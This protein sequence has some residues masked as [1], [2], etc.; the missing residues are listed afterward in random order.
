MA[1]E[2]TEVDPIAA[3]A[4]LA[5]NETAV[6]TPRF[7]ER[8]GDAERRA[9]ARATA[10]LVLGR[11]CTEV[12]KMEQV[13]TKAGK[14]L[15]VCQSVSDEMRQFEMDCA[16]AKE[17]FEARHATSK[18]VDAIRREFNSSVDADHEIKNTANWHVFKRTCNTLFCKVSKH[19]RINTGKKDAGKAP[20]KGAPKNS[21]GKREPKSGKEKRRANNR[22][23]KESSGP[24]PAEAPRP[25]NAAAEPSESSS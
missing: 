14:Q 16:K 3:I 18:G 13:V 11:D 4:S 2:N 9:R 5:G 17:R 6:E 22:L 23:S 8:P 19:L 20:K 21:S 15:M 12:E 7:T 25:Q 10:S 24:K 1:S